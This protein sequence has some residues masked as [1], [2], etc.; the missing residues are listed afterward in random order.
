[1]ALSAL[2]SRIPLRKTTDQRQGLVRLLSGSALALL[3]LVLPTE[4]ADAAATW[5]TQPIVPPA[6]V[7]TGDLVAVSCVGTWCMAVGAHE[8]GFG[9]R[10]PLAESLSGGTWSLVSTP[11]PDGASAV[12]LQGVACTTPNAC[13]AVGF[14]VD[15]SGGRSNLIERWDGATWSIQ[16][17]ASPTGNGLSGI[18]CSAVDACTAVG[19]FKSATGER[20]FVERWNGSSWNVQGTPHVT[21]AVT[22][23]LSSVSCASATTCVAVGNFTD[24]ASTHTALAEVWNGT[25]WSVSLSSNPPGASGS[26]LNGVACPSTDSCTAVGVFSGDRIKQAALV[27]HWDGTSWAVLSLPQPQGAQLLN[28]ACAGASACTAVGTLGYVGTLAETWDGSSWTLQTTPN[29]AGGTDASLTGVACITNAACQAVGHYLAMGSASRRT[30]LAERRDGSTWLIQPTPNP[31]GATIS[32]LDDVACL[33]ATWCLAVGA[34]IKEDGTQVPLRER[35][36]G[37][38][39]S[40]VPIPSP[41]DGLQTALTH[42][43][44]LSTTACLAVGSTWE[45]ASGL[46]GIVERW[47]GSAWAIVSTQVPQDSV[48]SLLYGV[49][50]SAAN[51]CTAVGSFLTGDGTLVPLVERWDGTTWS[52]QSAAVPPD[53]FNVSLSGISC[54]G[55]NLCVAVGGKDSLADDNGALA[56]RWDGVSWTILP[57]PAP[58]QSAGGSSLG[59]IVCFSAISCMA[60]GEFAPIPEPHPGLSFSEGWDGT[61]WTIVPT[62]NPPGTDEAP[63]SGL[64]CMSASDCTAVGFYVDRSP[65]WLTLVQHWNGGSWTIQPSPTPSGAAYVNLDGVACVVGSGCVAVGSV[66][67][68]V[69]VPLVLR[70]SE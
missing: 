10:M 42:I 53:S 27:E 37:L 5:V 3:V 11:A 17:A 59:K 1:M 57:T 36:N 65:K 67:R 34:Y 56:E 20:T 30:T 31:R 41:S 40:M 24:S 15:G 6:T 14:V 26:V 33:T 7:P 4:I 25:T 16:T 46:N 2:Y 9:M 8:D 29:P 58:P 18:S 52:L 38:S 62:M 45:S 19:S 32:S 43:T 51:A 61:T 70:S 69:T 47:D 48:Y 22:S 23:T 68:E 39:W 66:N 49:S 63:L 54:I 50:C 21:G 44:C 13:T 64:S 12:S 55:A 28:I 60:I 35:W